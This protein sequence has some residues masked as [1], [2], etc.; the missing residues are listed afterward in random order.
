MI[1]DYSSIPVFLFSH[2]ERTV[3]FCAYC[4][5][6]LGFTNIINLNGETSF[7]EKLIEF[8]DIAYSLNDDFYIRVDADRFVFEGIFDLIDQFVKLGLDDCE[9]VGFD[10]LMNKTRHGTPHIYSNTLIE[11]IKS[12][13]VEIFNSNKPESDIMKQVKNKKSINIMTNLH[14]YEQRPSKIIN[15]LINRLYRNHAGHYDWDRL[16]RLGLSTEVDAALNYYKNN[17]SKTNC[18]YIG[19]F[20]KFDSNS[21]LIPQSE[22]PHLY[23]NY[24]RIYKEI[25]AK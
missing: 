16:R 24:L 1:S 7:Y 11:K 5:K 15:T 12:G 18:D 3:E 13:K 9:G 25:K 17:E 2:G 22:F 20:S 10:N 6:K 14:D 23:S 19:D 8:S 21:G 4:L